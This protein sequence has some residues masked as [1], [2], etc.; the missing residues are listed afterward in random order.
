MSHHLRDANDVVHFAWKTTA[1]L[2]IGM[3]VCWVR[4]DDDAIE[5]PTRR[6][7]AQNVHPPYSGYEVTDSPVTCIACLAHGAP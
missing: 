7:P 2:F 1:D 3:T 5:P 4:G 6:L